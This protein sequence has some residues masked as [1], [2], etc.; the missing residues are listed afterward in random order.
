MNWLALVRTMLTHTRTHTHKQ[1]QGHKN[2]C[3]HAHTHTCT[4]NQEAVEEP[5]VSS[6]LFQTNSIFIQDICK[7]IKTANKDWRNM[8]HPSGLD[9]I[10]SAALAVACLFLLRPSLWKSLLLSLVTFL[11]HLTP[12]YIHFLLFWMTLLSCL[13]SA[14]LLLLPLKRHAVLCSVLKARR[15]HSDHLFCF[16]FRSIL[17]L[18]FK[19]KE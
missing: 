5:I 12:S 1:T 10:L 16:F 18:W 11:H 17:L 13:Y 3:M 14:A 6:S 4:H 19:L 2:K 9:T 15:L 8:S 7:L